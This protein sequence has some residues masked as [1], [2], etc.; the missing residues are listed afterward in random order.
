LK[1]I[2]LTNK[3]IVDK[4]IKEVIE[5][6]MVII[7]ITN[8]D[9][10]TS[11]YEDIKEFFKDK[12]IG[13]QCISL[14]IINKML[15]DYENKSNIWMYYM[16]NIIPQIAIK[17][18]VSPK[19]FLYKD[20]SS[21]CF[22]GIDVSHIPFI[23]NNGYSIKHTSGSVSCI[24]DNDGYIFF[25]DYGNIENGEKI[26]K[27]YHNIKNDII[28][29]NLY[30]E[31]N[32][33]YKILNSIIKEYISKTGNIPN[34]VVLHRDG[35][36]RESELELIHDYFK[37]HIKYNKI[38]YTVISI[39]KHID[40]KIYLWVNNEAKTSPIRAYVNRNKN[41]AYMITSKPFNKDKISNPFKVKII[42]TNDDYSIE[43][44]C[45][46]IYLLSFPTHM[47][48]IV[49]LRLPMTIHYSDESSTNRNRDYLENNIV[50]NK[51]LC[52]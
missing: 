30:N 31:K 22:I 43:K 47:K 16:N 3:K 18:G 52:P 5:H 7:F 50:Y 37:T 12:N 46:D 15:K 33:I 25:Q 26:I 51:L 44:A 29:D 48:G 41:E 17:S 13:T 20:L 14:K 10:D 40:K 27:E 21:K 39:L 35:F 8:D 38:R 1:D 42:Y 9:K 28:K 49:K 2:K 34:N 6:K 36:C 4:W 23:D 19:F 45:K 11:R 32:T 24:F